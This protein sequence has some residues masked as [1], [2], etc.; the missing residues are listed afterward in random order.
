[1]GTSMGRWLWVFWVVGLLAVDVSTIQAGYIDAVLADGPRGYWRL[2]DAA[3][4]TTAVNSAITGVLLQGSYTPP[5]MD[6]T[7]LIPG[8][9]DTAAAFN[10]SSTYVFGSGINTASSSGGNVFANDWTIEAWLM[11]QAAA[12]WQGVFSNNRGGNGA[13]LMTFFGF[14]SPA[15]HRL[16]INAAGISSAGISV[17]LNQYGGGGNAYLGQPIYAVITKTGG[18]TAGTNSILVK[19]NVGGQ[20]LSSATGSTSWNLNPQDGFYIGR[21]YDGGPQIMNGT[22]D[23]VAIY[24]SALSPQKI[25][26]H[27]A[28]AALRWYPAAVVSSGPVAYW[29]LGEPAGATKALN[30]G[31]GGVALDGTYSPAK[32][33][34]PSI[35]LRSPDS[36]ADFNGSNAYVFGAGLNTASTTGG[37]PF[38]NDWTIEAWFIR[39]TA[40]ADW[41]AI[42]SN[43]ADSA[44]GG[45]AP[46]LTFFD[47]SGGRSRSWLG[48]NPAGISPTPDIYVDLNQY[49]GGNNAYLGKPVYAVLSKSGSQLRM[50]VNVDGVWL[51]PAAATLTRT[52]D[53]NNDKWFIGRHY[54]GGIY[55][56]GKI[57]DVA[58]YDRALS[59]QEVLAHYQ[60]SVPEPSSLILLGVGLVVL[61]SWGQRKLPAVQ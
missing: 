12:D 45:G 56:D 41:Q 31:W 29:R 43:N 6:A 52:L 46:V 54:W 16:G 39:D 14:G 57:D 38:A 17:D 28:A 26:A 44:E 61:L 25:M 40:G 36:A 50:Y 7:G 32:T 59:W 15:Y 19:V 9:P 23:E 53:T 4:S 34:A 55:F 47:S 48:M 30:S 2:G 37:N 42:F 22:I 21:H 49:G 11:R 20:W 5:K 1:M 18:N 10:G 3:G 27:Y 33:S 60:A 24:E 35:F 8:D 51:P 58:L 13:P